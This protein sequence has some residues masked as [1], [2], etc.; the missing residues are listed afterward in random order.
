MVHHTLVCMLQAQLYRYRTVT[1]SSQPSLAKLAEVYAHNMAS[2]RNMAQWC[3]AHG[4]ASYRVPSSLFPLATHR[5]YRAAVRPLVQEALATL[6]PEDFDGLH[7]SSHPDQ[8]VVLSSLNP[9]T[10]ESSLRELEFW[11]EATPWLP[12]K[13]IN[14]HVGSKAQP[15]ENLRVLETSIGRL[16]DAARCRLSLENDEKSYS[17]AETLA[18][19]EAFGVMA[20]PDFHHE[21]CH[22]RRHHPE[23]SPYASDAALYEA[24]PRVL[25]TYTGREALPTFHISSP[26]GGWSGRFVDECKHADFIEASDYPLGLHQL[27]IPVCLDIEAKAKENALLALATWLRQNA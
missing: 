7:L 4:I 2:L 21:R 5:D 23:L 15:E 3:K 6:N 22:Q 1:A 16:S 18:I 11:A 26:L 13:L 25:A 27:D 12:L 24:L 9:E 8:F 17:F 14:V 19:A 20:V 10:V